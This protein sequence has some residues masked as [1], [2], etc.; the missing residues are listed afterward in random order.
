MPRTSTEVLQE[1]LYR[2][3]SLHRPDLAREV[4]DLF[5]E[6][7][8]VILSG[9][10]GY[11]PRTR[12]GLRLAGIS[13][14]DAVHAAVL[15]NHGVEWIATFDDGFDEH[16]HISGAGLRKTIRPRRRTLP[17]AVSFR[18]RSGTIHC[19][20]SPGP[21]PIGAMGGEVSS[22][23][24]PPMPQLCSRPTVLKS[25]LLPKRLAPKRCEC[26]VPSSRQ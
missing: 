18:K 14:R 6:T 16:S 26:S 23:T 7:Y 8:P 5:V 4:H 13:A 12:F 17:S 22:S 25:Q 10:G 19:R 20:A 21:A 3:S 2:Y 24:K 9:A 1:I 15:L 11:G